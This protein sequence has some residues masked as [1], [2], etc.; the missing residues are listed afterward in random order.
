[1]SEK[2]WFDEVVCS[3][4]AARMVDV[5]AGKKVIAHLG[6]D[7]LRFGQHQVDDGKI[8]LSVAADGQVFYR[9]ELF[10]NYAAAKSYC[11][12][13]LAAIHQNV[14]KSFGLN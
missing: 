5:I 12:A 13:L 4:N 7:D 2:I 3:K 8:L 6:S 9:T 10:A 1:M 11:D 14:L